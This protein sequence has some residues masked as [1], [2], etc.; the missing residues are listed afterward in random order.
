[1]IKHRPLRHPR[2][3]VSWRPRAKRPDSSGPTGRLPLV[4]PVTA[5][6]KRRR[7]RWSHWW[8][9]RVH[10]GWGRGCM[11]ECV[12]VIRPR[13]SG[14]A[15]KRFSPLPR[16][17]STSATAS[18]LPVGISCRWVQLMLDWDDLDVLMPLT[19]FAYPQVISRNFPSFRGVKLDVSAGQRLFGLGWFPAAPPRRCRSGP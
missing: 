19:P 14:A 4:L 18:P 1:M 13:P 6:V 5:P 17:A 11:L 15:R 16:S 12:C 7:R 2:Q 8:C 9:K 10:C 3:P